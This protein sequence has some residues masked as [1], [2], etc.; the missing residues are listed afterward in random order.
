MSPYSKDYT[1]SRAAHDLWDHSWR[2]GLLRLHPPLHARTIGYH[3]FRLFATAGVQMRAVGWAHTTPTRRMA[4]AAALWKFTF[5]RT[6][7]A[8]STFHLMMVT[9]ACPRGKCE[10][11]NS[12]AAAPLYYDGT[13]SEI[14]KFSPAIRRLLPMMVNGLSGGFG[15]CSATRNGPTVYH[16][17]SSGFFACT[18]SVLTVPVI[19]W[20]FA[21]RNITIYENDANQ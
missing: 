4:A 5:F 3:L 15:S 7:C 13:K 1:F 9:V 12:A 14:F 16:H 10:A 11:A 17:L 8:H 6:I 2:G 20:A 21:T 18:S 19:A